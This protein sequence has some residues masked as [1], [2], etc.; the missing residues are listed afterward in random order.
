[1]IFSQHKNFWVGALIMNVFAFILF[2]SCK[3]EAKSDV[4]FEYDVEKIPSM[5]THNDTMLISDSGIIR[6]KLLAK[7]W[8]VYEQ[9]KEPHWYFPDKLYLEQ[10]DS[11]FNV[12]VTIEA[13][14]AW[15]YTRKKL[16]RLKG[17]VFVK[18]I[19]DE[20][21]ASDELYWD[22]Q[23]QKIYSDTLVTI[24]RP[25]KALLIANSFV[26]NQQMT[27]YTFKNVGRGTKLWVNENE[28]NTENNNQAPAE[29]KSE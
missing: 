16:W 2:T 29:E 27:E 6:Y 15:N 24:N 8:E 5:R 22:Q 12:V 9:A 4:D 26:S 3:E 28:E 13:D 18:N 17:H 23:K 14:T 1:M 7:T 21:F 11:V 25:E 10:F 19:N 20:T